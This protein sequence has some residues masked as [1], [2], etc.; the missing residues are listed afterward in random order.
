MVEPKILVN[1]FKTKCHKFKID[2]FEISLGYDTLLEQDVFLYIT[3]KAV[4]PGLLQKAYY[5]NSDMILP[6]LSNFK[7]EGE[8]FLYTTKSQLG[9]TLKKQYPKKALLEKPLSRSF[10]NDFIFT[11]AK[12]C[13]RI[14]RVGGYP[15]GI[16]PET[17]ILENQEDGIFQ[18]AVIGQGLIINQTNFSPFGYNDLASQSKMCANDLINLYNYLQISDFTVETTQDIDKVNTK[19]FPFGVDISSIDDLVDYLQNLG[20]KIILNEPK[21][22]YNIDKFSNI[23]NGKVENNTNQNLID[24]ALDKKNNQI[25]DSVEN[26]SPKANFENEKVENNKRE[27]NFSDESSNQTNSQ[28]TNLPTEKPLS[29]K[30]IKG[31]VLFMYSILGAVVLAV[32]MAVLVLIGVIG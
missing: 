14:G 16:N 10:I 24:K 5:R 32:V 6:V 13:Q 30:H 11:I 29:K 26:V 22:L 21:K 20:A 27:R 28:K 18:F 8:R 15:L 4:D 17:V 19:K 1:R 2:N 31:S 25:I 12:E 3:N 7:L 9:T 23:E